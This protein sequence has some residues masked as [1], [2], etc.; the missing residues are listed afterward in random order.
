[1]RAQDR[2]GAWQTEE[3]APPAP[4]GSTGYHRIYVVVQ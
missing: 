3:E 2:T 4:D 1:M